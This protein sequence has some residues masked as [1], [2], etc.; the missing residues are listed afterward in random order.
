MHQAPDLGAEARVKADDG[1]EELPVGVP[2]DILLHAAVKVLE[3]PGQR[4]HEDALDR[5]VEPGQVECEGAQLR[6]DAVAARVGGDGDEL[7]EPT[8]W[9][10]ALTGLEDRLAIHHSRVIDALHVEHRHN[11]AVLGADQVRGRR[12]REAHQQH[13]TGAAVLGRP[14]RLLQLQE[15]GKVRN[16]GEADPEVAACEVLSQESAPAARTPARADTPDAAGEKA[17]HCRSQR[18]HGGRHHVLPREAL[19]SGHAAPRGSTALIQEGLLDEAD[20]V[21]APQDGAPALELAHERGQHVQRRAAP[22]APVL[23]RGVRQVRLCERPRRGLPRQAQGEGFPTPQAAGAGAHVQRRGRVDVRPRQLR[24]ELRGLGRVV[25]EDVHAA[26]GRRRRLLPIGRHP[27]HG[28]GVLTEQLAARRALLDVREELAE[29]PGRGPRELYH[30]RAWLG[31]GVVAAKD[32][33]QDAR[34]GRQQRLRL[35]KAARVRQGL[36]RVCQALRRR[37][38][39]GRTALEGPRE[40]AERQGA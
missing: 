12:G 38:L 20:A 15:P 6:A 19:R 23:E 1:V 5:G 9:H 13:L 27:D 8:A 2:V 3:A 29:Q 21:G 36:L 34:Q 40:T 14:R 31:A 37:G 16:L 25:R 17:R 30:Q 18:C 11:L 4:D 22:S 26:G 28:Q 10:V 7:E 24:E 35:Y 39:G 33:I 32:A